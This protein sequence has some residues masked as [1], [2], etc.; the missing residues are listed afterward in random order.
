MGVVIEMSLLENVHFYSLL[1]YRM[2]YFARDAIA[3]LH[4][5]GG[6]NNKKNHF[7]TILEARCMILKCQRVGFF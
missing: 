3:M 4:R 7:L 2:Y 1:A 5:L 6:F